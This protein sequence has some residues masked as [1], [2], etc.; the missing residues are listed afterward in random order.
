M[1]RVLLLGGPCHPK[2][3][4]LAPPSGFV[5]RSSSQRRKSRVWGGRRSLWEGTQSS[6]CFLLQP[7]KLSRGSRV[8]QQRELQPQG[9]A[10]TTLP[11]PK[12]RED[13]KGF[14]HILSHRSFRA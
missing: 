1:F 2:P 5:R 6:F 11:G 12:R 4:L 8:H 10:P 3:V 7:L 14:A 13:V 9:A